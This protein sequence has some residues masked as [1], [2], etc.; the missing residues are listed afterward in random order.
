MGHLCRSYTQLVLINPTQMTGQVEG[1]CVSKSVQL[2]GSPNTAPPQS[3]WVLWQVIRIGVIRTPM[4]LQI[5]VAIGGSV[6]GWVLG[7]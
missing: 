7:Q 5:Q 3:S 6:S 2:P 4:F 1:K